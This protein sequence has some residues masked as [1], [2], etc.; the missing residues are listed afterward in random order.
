MPA[1]A[2]RF[3]FPQDDHIW[4]IRWVGSLRESGIQA[5][6]DVDV[7]LAPV[8]PPRNTP[9][10]DQTT[11]PA[12]DQIRIVRIGTG[13]LPSLIV[14]SRWQ[15]GFVLPPRRYERF[16]QIVRFE[17]DNMQLVDAGKKLDEK[18]YLIPPFEYRLPLG[19]MASKCVAIGI[20]DDPFALIIPCHEVL[21]AW[22]LRSTAMALHLLSGP[23]NQIRNSIFDVARSGEES[24]GHWRVQLRNRMSG[25]DALPAALL[26]CDPVAQI[27]VRRMFDALIKQKLS[28]SPRWIQLLP[29]AQTV[30][31]LVA[32]GRWFTSGSRKRFLVFDVQKLPFPANIRQIE[33]DLDNS[34]QK[35]HGEG[36]DFE[37][38]RRRP[39][40]ARDSTRA[41][42]LLEAEEPKRDNITALEQYQPPELNHSA[43]II[44]CDKT[45]QSGHGKR[46]PLPKSDSTVHATGP[47]THGESGSAPLRIIASDGERTQLPVVAAAFTGMIEI[48]REINRIEGAFAEAVALTTDYVGEAG[49]Y[50][51]IFPPGEANG[52][53]YKSWCFIGTRR[54]QLIC[55]RIEHNNH[56]GY[57]LEIERA[58][59]PDDS[60][61][62]GEQYQLLLIV[63]DG[64]EQV[65]DDVFETTIERCISKNG[66]WPDRIDGHQLR[67]FKHTKS[68]SAFAI[69][70]V[71]GIYET[72][73]I[74][75]PTVIPVPEET[76]QRS[77]N[78]A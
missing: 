32:R 72:L 42:V 43:R 16:N 4:V 76:Q 56:I 49:E 39:V 54:R 74:K 37:V 77:L 69:A 33:W 46:I 40:G 52:R 41:D 64:G 10:P 11:A 65:D 78:T 60:D 8:D 66:V 53:R 2:L 27:E 44:R 71:T 6:F 67:K 55:A 20:N 17:P 9:E 28:G 19:M 48:I 45:D 38:W 22:L 61:R 29:P 31:Q 24:P 70:L 23:F 30:G 62:K 26:A 57:A 25:Q 50:R 51:S 14:G 34:N 15:K 5:Q 75:P 13:A 21:R 59:R 47:G 7:A 3:M 73:G 68:T 36:E 1:P 58:P 12:N 35:Q 63:R 18:N